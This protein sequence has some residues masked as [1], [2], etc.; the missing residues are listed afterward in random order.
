MPAILLTPLLILIGWLLDA[1]GFTGIVVCVAML[2]VVLGTIVFLD[3]KSDDA[4]E[5][6]R[7]S[8]VQ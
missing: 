8:R 6:Y 3:I 4:Q 2:L 7:N 1:F 5:R